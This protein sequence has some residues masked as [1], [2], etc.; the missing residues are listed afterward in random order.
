[1]FVDRCRC[2]KAR[3]VIGV[4]ET[5]SVQTEVLPGACEKLCCGQERTK[6]YVSHQGGWMEDTG[7][8]V[9]AIDII[10]RIITSLDFDNTV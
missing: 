8:S 5:E 7:D 6:E 1:L 10:S 4:R 9:G 3:D 2:S